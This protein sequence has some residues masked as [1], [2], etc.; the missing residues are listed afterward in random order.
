MLIEYNLVC[1]GSM[2]IAPQRI[3]HGREF[4]TWLELVSGE[5]TFRFLGTEH[6]SP[7][8]RS[9]NESCNAKYA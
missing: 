5:N 6:V 3:Q 2:P 9:A 4:R 1:I 7:S 8:S